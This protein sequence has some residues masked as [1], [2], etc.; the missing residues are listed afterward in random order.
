M[1]HRTSLIVQLVKNFPAIQ[2]TLAQIL[3]WEELLEKGYAIHSSIWG[4]PGGS[5]CKETACSE[6]SIPGFGRSPRARKWLPTTLF[7]LE[8]SMGSGTW[9]TALHGVTNRQG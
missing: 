2:E 9:Q 8:N 6:D 3:G 7:L 4:V 5:E 1:D